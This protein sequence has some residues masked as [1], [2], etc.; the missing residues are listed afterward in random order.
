MT[1]TQV[2]M[3]VEQ[4]LALPEEKPYREYVCGEVIAK[5]MPDDDHGQLVYTLAQLAGPALT[6]LGGRAGPEIRCRF[7]TERGP[8]YR[9]P[10]FAYWRPDK[11]RKDGD[12]V[13]PPT[14]A[15]EVRSANETASEQRAKCAYYRHY[16]V[17][18]CWLI[19]PVSRTVEVFEGDLEAEPLAPDA[20]LT[21]PLLPGL[22]IPVR[23]L[24]AALD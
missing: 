1:S 22:A 5:A 11:P 18:V 4:Y 8:E 23:Q 9:L 16:G 17:D 21:S 3:T 24:F 15:V 10:D 19:N 20:S 7:D 14:L 2:R 13:L 12:D 6:E